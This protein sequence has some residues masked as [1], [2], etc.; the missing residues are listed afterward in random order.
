VGLDGV[1]R[2]SPGGRFGLPVAV[3][4]VWRNDSTFV[5]DYDEV[6]N[7]NRYTL[8]LGFSGDRLDAEMTEHTG[9]M[10]ARFGGSARATGPQ[11]SR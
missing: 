9:L 1:P 3:S 8:T 4:G 2:L 11:A 10:H 5:L 7:I 6:A